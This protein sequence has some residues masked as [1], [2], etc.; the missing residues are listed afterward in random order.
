LNERIEC[1][2]GTSST[3]IPA[4][5]TRSATRSC[6]RPS[7]GPREPG[8]GGRGADREGD[9]DQARQEGP[10]DRK[11]FPGYVLAKLAMNDDVYHLVKNTPKVTGFLG[12]TASRSRSARPRRRASSTPRKRPPPPRPSKKISVD[13]EIGDRSRCSTA[14]SPA[15]TASSRS[16][17]ST[18]AGQGQRL[19]LRPRDPGRARVRTGRTASNSSVATGASNMSDCA[20]VWPNM[21]GWR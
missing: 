19:D 10:V 17:I 21:S 4:S 7:A 9:R 20:G 11:F 12:P 8:R 18:A 5:R 3:L 14:R 13:Y 15:S 6:P 2:A 16:S 1:P